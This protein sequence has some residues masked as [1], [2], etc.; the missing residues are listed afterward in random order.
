[1]ST[2]ARANGHAAA[3][4]TAMDALELALVNGDLSK[5]SP[6]Q[7]LAYYRSRCEA[8]GL[9]PRSQPFEYITL[10]GKLTL[11]AKK[12]CS[13]QLIANRKLSVTILRRGYDTGSGCY[14]VECRATYPD[15]QAVDDLGVVTIHGLKGEALA[16]VIMKT[17]TKAKRR[18]V[19]SACGLG[20]LDESEVESIPQAR[21]ERAPEPPRKA[22]EPPLAPSANESFHKVP[23]VLVEPRPISD[24]RRWIQD[25][26]DRANADWAT[27]CA[28]S[29]KDYEPLAKH[30]NQ[31]V[32]G[33]ISM[34]VEGGEMEEEVVCN[35][36]GK[37]DKDKVGALLKE[38]WD[39]NPDAFQGDVEDYLQR[40][41]EE[42]AKAIDIN[43]DAEPAE[44]EPAEA[45]ADA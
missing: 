28:L 9:D 24:V 38:T 11:Y 36:A 5:L 33:L 42:A 32:H 25:R 44:P 14:E 10:N 29:R 26:L 41:L 19:L 2:P 17:A 30:V 22:I 8:A 16:N 15:G 43:L 18:T 13:D 34:W 39:A 20:M 27:T 40:K 12:S 31:V 21:V 6:E 3:P 35:D 23:P 45:P 37:R 7:R 4:A 1:M